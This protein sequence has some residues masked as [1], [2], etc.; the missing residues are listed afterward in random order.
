MAPGTPPAC[1]IC[2]P[3]CCP[4]QPGTFHREQDPRNGTTHTTAELAPA[5]VD[6]IITRLVDDP[7]A[8]AAKWKK[9]PYLM[10]YEDP[11]T[12]KPGANVLLNMIT[13][14]GQQAA[15]ADYRKFRPRP[16]RDHGDGRQLALADEFPLGDTAHTSSGNSCC[17][18]WFPI[19]PAKSPLPCPLK[20]CSI[21][22]HHHLRR[23][24]RSGIQSCARR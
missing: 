20:C 6:S 22:A 18:G 3:P 24:A 4:L 8:N 23:C 17:A 12:P 10:D 19:R 16:H 21:T 7:A 14:E 9:L 11:G 13:P 5:G 2:C 1:S 15:A